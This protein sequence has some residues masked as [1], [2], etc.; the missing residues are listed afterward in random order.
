[1]IE[2][3]DIL[4]KA[5]GLGACSQSSKATDWKSLVWLFFSPQGCEF[6]KSIN[7]PSLEM[8]RS[9]KG[10]VESFGVYIEENV[11]AVNEDKAII[12]GTAELTF[13]GTDKA[14]KVIIMH[15]G[16]VRIKISNYA[17]VRIENISGYYEIINDG[18]GKV[19]I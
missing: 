12:G 17:V 8:F 5:I 15:G 9:M 2:V 18:T 4:N 14:Y 11:K 6:C 19:L 7:Y 13:Q 1:M 16:N 3:K 10:N